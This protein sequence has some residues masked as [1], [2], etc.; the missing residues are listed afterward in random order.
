MVHQVRCRLV[1]TDGR[2]LI[3][4]ADAVI[5][6]DQATGKWSGMVT[7]DRGGDGA[8]VF[9]AKTAVLQVAGGR[10]GEIIVRDFGG[11]SIGVEGTGPAPVG[12]TTGT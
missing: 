12:P 5:Q 10:S 3:A 1:T 8:A 4:D 6:V 2:E 7:L 11:N 9:N